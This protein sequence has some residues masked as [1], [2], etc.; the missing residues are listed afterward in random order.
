MLTSAVPASQLYDLYE[1]ATRMLD[2]TSLQ[3]I[4]A[5]PDD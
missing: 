1:F 4:A 3:K 5:A 2:C